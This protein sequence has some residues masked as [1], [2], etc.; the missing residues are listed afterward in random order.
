MRERARDTVNECVGECPNVRG[1]QWSA[2][3]IQVCAIRI[4][5]SPFRDKSEMG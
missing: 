1:V 4:V 3:G 2:L 5:V